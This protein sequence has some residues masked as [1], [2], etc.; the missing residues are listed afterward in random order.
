MEKPYNK[1]NQDQDQTL[2][3]IMS[4]LLANSGLNWRK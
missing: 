4:S 2:A 3:Q 1:Q